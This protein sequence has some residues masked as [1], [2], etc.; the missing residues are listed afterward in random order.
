VTIVPHGGVRRVILNG[1]VGRGEYPLR[2]RVLIP[3]IPYVQLQRQSSALAL[4]YGYAAVSFLMKDDSTRRSTALRLHQIQT[5]RQT[6]TTAC[7]KGQQRDKLYWFESVRRDTSKPDPQYAWSGR[8][9]RSA[10]N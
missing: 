3:P 5:S 4:A 10:M 8:R 1:A 7:R 6:T 9:G 2:S